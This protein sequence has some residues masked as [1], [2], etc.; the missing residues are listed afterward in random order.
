MC[1]LV[2]SPGFQNRADSRSAVHC[3]VLATL[4]TKLA[5]CVAKLLAVTK[6]LLAAF[7]TSHSKLNGVFAGCAGLGDLCLS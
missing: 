6:R 1:R 4:A 5:V 3:L 2:S 7:I